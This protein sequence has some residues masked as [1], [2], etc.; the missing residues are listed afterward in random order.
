MPPRILAALVVLSLAPHAFADAVPP[1]PDDCPSGTEPVTDHGG[2]RCEK[3]APKNCPS[4]WRGVIGGECVLHQCTADADC[5][6][7]GRVCRPASLCFE[8]HQ[9][10]STCQGSRSNALGAPPVL[11]GPCMQLPEPV[12]DWNPVNVCGGTERCASPGECR[13]SKLCVVPNSP[14]PKVMPRDESGQVQ[15]KPSGCGS[16]CVSA[17][18]HSGTAAALMAIGALGAALA[19][20]RRR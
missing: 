10:Y 15:S 6:E 12:T 18:G 9:R 19:L 2:P 1:P 14:S 11:G 20:R 13:P 4:G 5:R 7:T 3:A 17:P 16:G 8:P